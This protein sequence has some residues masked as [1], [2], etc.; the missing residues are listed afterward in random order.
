MKPSDIRLANVASP[1]G[2]TFGRVENEVAMAYGIL[3][4]KFFGD[5]WRTIRGGD[6][7]HAISLYRE[8]PEYRWLL[9]PFCRPDF[10]TIREKG[11]VEDVGLTGQGWIYRFTDEAL[12]RLAFSPWCRPGVRK[13]GPVAPTKN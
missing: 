13:Q 1:L 9:N 7:Y 5:E 2:G 6:L 11:L 10:F 4:C 8:R 12:E 3:V